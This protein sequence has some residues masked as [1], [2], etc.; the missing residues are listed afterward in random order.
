MNRFQLSPR[1]AKAQLVAEHSRS[2]Y[3]A[4]EDEGEDEQQEEEKVQGVPRW[5]DVLGDDVGVVMRRRAEGGYGLKDVRLFRNVA[6][7]IS[8]RF[9]YPSSCSVHAQ[10]VD[11]RAIRWS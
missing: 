2:A 5:V 7:P 1:S 4:N 8:D 3:R 10:C 11:R 6:S 9:S